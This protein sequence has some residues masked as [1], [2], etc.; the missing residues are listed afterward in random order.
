MIVEDVQTSG[1]RRNSQ[2]MIEVGR[3]VHMG[4]FYNT[5]PVL[6]TDDVPLGD[7]GLEY[8]DKAWCW[9]EANMAELGGQLDQL[10]HHIKDM[11]MVELE[12]LITAARLPVASCDFQICSTSNATSCGWHFGHRFAVAGWWMVEGRLGVE[13]GV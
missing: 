4:V 7:D 10:S 5:L 1:M 6:V 8:L 12:C 3:M 13:G 9:A 11:L 2:G